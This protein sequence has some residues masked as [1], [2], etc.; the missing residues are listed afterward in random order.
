MEGKEQRPVM[1][2]WL[3]FENRFDVEHNW[4]KKPGKTDN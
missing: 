4:A 2:K 1:L 3:I